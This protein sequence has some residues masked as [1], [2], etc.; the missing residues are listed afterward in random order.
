MVPAVV[1]AQEQKHLKAVPELS[2][3]SNV[4]SIA[5]V[6]KNNIVIYRQNRYCMPKG[7][8]QPGKK[9][10][11]EP[12]EMS[13]IVHFYDLKDN[14]LIE[15]HQIYAGIGKCIRNNHPERDKFTKLQAIKDKVLLGF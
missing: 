12:D 6:R 10:K 3:P 11:I 15:E 4:P 14:A 2:E 8:Y 13:R 9:V 7:T 1:F 5:V